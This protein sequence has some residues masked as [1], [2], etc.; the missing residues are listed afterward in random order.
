MSN[1]LE[2]HADEVFSRSICMKKNKFDN[3]L[4]NIFVD[5]SSQRECSHVRR[6]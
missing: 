2:Y 6:E 4:I 5:F 1:K 3:G